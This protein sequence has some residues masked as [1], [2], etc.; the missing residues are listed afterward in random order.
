MKLTMDQY[1]KTN[2][3]ISIWLRP[4]QAVSEFVT[5]GSE[6]K[7]HLLAVLSGISTV[8]DNLSNQSKGD[9]IGIY[10]IF[11]VALVAG[12][13]VGVVSLHI[14]TIS[15]F[16]TGRIFKGKATLRELRASM[17]LSCIPTIWL[18]LLWIP[19][20]YFYG[21][22]SFQSNTPNITASPIPFFAINILNMV[23]GIWG[24]V[25]LCKCI[26]QVQHFSAWHSLICL[27]I[28]GIIFIVAMFVFWPER[29]HSL[30]SQFG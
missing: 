1:R 3:W 2:P 21:N 13:F 16:L 28:L 15:L 17:S 23:I 12:T 10:L 27:L 4:R 20:V 7:F 22:E 8:L 25:I 24:F 19:L 11:I 29:M 18:L 9:V 6:W 14:W 26:S 30:I 5:K